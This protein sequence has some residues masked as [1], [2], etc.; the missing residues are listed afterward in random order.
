M[1]NLERGTKLSQSVEWDG[2]AIF[3]IAQAAF[4]DA[5]FHTFNEIFT[6]AWNKFNQERY[7]AS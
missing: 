1:N 4:E 2:Q 3:E 5:N 6:E 7:D